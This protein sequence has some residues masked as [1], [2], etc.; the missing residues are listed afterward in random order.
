[1]SRI[2]VF[3]AC[4]IL[5]VLALP[6]QASARRG[7][8][9]FRGGGFRGGGF[10]GGMGRGF[11]GGRRG[12]AGRG[13]RGWGGRGWGWGAAAAV[14]AL[15]YYGYYSGSGYYGGNG[16]YYDDRYERRAPR[17]YGYYRDAEVVEPGVVVRPS[18]CGQFR[19][20]NGT[21]C[22]DARINPPNLN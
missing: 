13:G 10:R 16:Y 22:V 9:G 19:Y 15:P 6:E 3:I 17:V 8:G 20:W 2:A 12:I 18:N 4:A 11:R 1:M 14:A 5:L 7:G 21:A